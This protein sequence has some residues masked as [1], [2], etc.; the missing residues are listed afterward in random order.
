MFCLVTAN[1]AFFRAFALGVHARR[2]ARFFLDFI[3]A[4]ATSTPTRF[5]E[6]A[7]VNAR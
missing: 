5:D 7:R 1:G 6:V 3:F 2:S 4:S